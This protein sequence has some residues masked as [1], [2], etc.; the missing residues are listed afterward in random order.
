VIEIHA[1]EVFVT[2]SIGVAAGLEEPEELMRRADLAMYE[3]KGR[4]KGRYELFLS[5]M[6]EATSRS[7]SWRGGASWASRRCCAGCTRPAA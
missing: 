6:R 5:H 1:H 3:A 4:G 2:A 7:S